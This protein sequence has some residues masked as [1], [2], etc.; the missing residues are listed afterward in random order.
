M[1]SLRQRKKK[2]NIEKTAQLYNV[3]NLV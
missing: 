3:V 1:G 2:K